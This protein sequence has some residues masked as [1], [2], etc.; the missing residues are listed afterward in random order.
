MAVWRLRVSRP[1]RPLVSL[2]LLSA[3]VLLGFRMKTDKAKTGTHHARGKISTKRNGNA[4]RQTTERVGND[5][6]TS[7]TY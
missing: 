4:R 5:V 2:A 7:A 1:K 3:R 6:R